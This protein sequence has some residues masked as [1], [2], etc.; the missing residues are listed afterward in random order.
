VTLQPGKKY[1]ALVSRESTIKKIIMVPHKLNGILESKYKLNDSELSNNCVNE[2]LNINDPQDLDC[3]VQDILSRYLSAEHL[4][5]ATHHIK[6]ILES[7]GC[8]NRRDNYFEYMRYL[9]KQII[10]HNIIKAYKIQF[11]N[12]LELGDSSKSIFKE[13]DLVNILDKQNDFSR[14]NVNGIVYILNTC[15]FLVPDYNT[16]ILNDEA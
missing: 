15:V 16:N 7:L 10:H 8:L 11:D 2:L 4:E 14:D 13:L 5:T 3:N 6:H 1:K 12:L 9:F